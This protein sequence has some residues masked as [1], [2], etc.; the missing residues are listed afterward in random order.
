[1]SEPEKKPALEALEGGKATEKPSQLRSEKELR[2]ALTQL[3]QRHAIQKNYLQLQAST[4]NLRGMIDASVDL[5]VIE[6]HIE[7]LRFALKEADSIR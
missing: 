3:V 1:M 7:A 2:D 6:A 4:V 5:R